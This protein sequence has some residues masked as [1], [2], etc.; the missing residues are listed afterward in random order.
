MANDFD[1][2]GKIIRIKEIKPELSERIRKRSVGY[3]AMNQKPDP[4]AGQKG[5]MG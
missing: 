2:N 3:I 1:E 4:N 5:E